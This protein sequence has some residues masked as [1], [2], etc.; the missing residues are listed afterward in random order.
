MDPGYN[1]TAS[2]TCDKTDKTVFW[3]YGIGSTDAF[4]VKERVSFGKNLTIQNYT[5]GLAT[6][7]GDSYDM[8]TFNG[9]CG[10][11]LGKDYC[12]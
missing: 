8:N 2:T 7:V 11:G 12:H 10:L 6:E 9:I 3:Q 4:L 5:L 1:C